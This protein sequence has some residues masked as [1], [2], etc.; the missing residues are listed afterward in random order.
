MPTEI[1]VVKNLK[2]Y[3]Y[4]SNKENVH[5]VDG[6][7]FS[8]FK[9]ETLGLVGESGSGKT[10]VGRC[11]IR[12]LEP[13]DGE[14]IFKEKNLLKYSKKEMRKIRKDIQIIFQDPFSSLDPRKTTEQL[15]SEP[16]IIHNYGNKKAIKKKVDDLLNRVNL[17]RSV[18]NKYTHELDGGRCQRIGLA[19]AIALAPSFLVCDEPVSALDV[20]SQAQV[21]RLLEEFQKEHEIAYLLI[22]HDLSV[23]RKLSQRIIVMYLGLFV[24]IANSNE[25]FEKPLHPYTKALI[26]AVPTLDINQKKHTIILKGDVPTPINHEKG[27]RFFKRCEYSLKECAHVSPPLIEKSNG[28]FVRCHLFN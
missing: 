15:I 8:I 18:I 27:C 21:M 2:K 14:I 17:D 19:R 9:G 6:V 1:M 28:H 16:L 22:S 12:L 5:A 4:I 3:F 26:S 25:L 10:T 13:D 23:V 7:S 20:S 24:E 11:V